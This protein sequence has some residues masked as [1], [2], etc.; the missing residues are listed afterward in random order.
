M[1]TQMGNAVDRLLETEPFVLTS[2]EKQMQFREAIKDAF[3]HHMANNY[4]FHNYCKKKGLD[5]SSFPKDLANLPY[6][7]VRL[8]KTK[9]LSSV[10]QDK[11]K[12]VLYSSATTGTPSTIVID[13]T[14]TKRQTLISTKI[15]SEYLGNHRRPFLILDDDPNQADSGEITAR[16]A[17]TRGFLMFASSA[18]YFLSDNH[19][20]LT[21]NLD[22]LMTYLT[23][24]QDSQEECT[25]FGFTF[26]LYHHVIRIFKQKGFKFHLAPSSKVIHIGGWKKLED[27]KVSK[28]Q[29]ISDIQEVLGLPPE[30]VFDFYG[31]TE[32]MG[33]VYA[34]QGVAP[35]SVPAYAE[36]I[37]R[38]FQTLEPAPD[39]KEGLIQ[40]L[41]PMPHSYPGI[42]IL[43]EDVGRILGHGQDAS[44]RLGTQ[45]EIIGRANKAET[46]G[47]GDIMSEYIE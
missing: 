37:I 23:T 26:I 15:M 35:K 8:F 16:S 36:V 1:T 38:D 43:T 19:G 41:T 40:I 28:D 39:G 10:G 34:N 12:K 4:M 25:L 32:Q 47:C 31:F 9:N 30:S 17:A 21:L 20:N 5:L 11:V 3:T 18:D 7:P 42:S 27:Q 22:K 6:L 24:F 44:G 14:T 13:A 46:R 29:F 2:E 45:F 33:L